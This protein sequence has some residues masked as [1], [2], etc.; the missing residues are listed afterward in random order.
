MSDARSD[1]RRLLAKVKRL[2]RESLRLL[3]QAGRWTPD[4]DVLDL[5]RESEGL[6]VL[7]AESLRSGRALDPWTVGLWLYE[8]GY[9]CPPDSPEGE[10]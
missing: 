2:Q 8:H 6:I 1:L 9:K 4:E 5:L 10:R 3:N 7:L